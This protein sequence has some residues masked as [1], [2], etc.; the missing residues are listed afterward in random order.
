M[1][2]A[3]QRAALITEHLFPAGPVVA[4]VGSGNNGGDALVCLRALSAWGRRVVAVQV[5][6]RPHP[7]PVLHGWE[8]PCTIF[9]P[10]RPGATEELTRILAGASA[11]VDGLLGTGIRGA[12]RPP[13][14][15]A[16]RA[17]NDAAA[18]AVALDA[19]S[20]VDGTSGEVPGDA[21]RAA[22]TVAFGWPKLGTLL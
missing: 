22:V 7:D 20:G 3:G 14:A 15:T 21:I 10:R 12:P 11:V 17:V 19:P 4:L 6:R 16:I 8:I 9:D 18:A 2:N 1:E 5:G 13:H